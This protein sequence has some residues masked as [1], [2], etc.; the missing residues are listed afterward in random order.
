MTAFAAMSY[1]WPSLS[2]SR[3]GMPRGLW[4]K[5]GQRASQGQG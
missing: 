2:Y 5:V 4:D 1:S 3:V